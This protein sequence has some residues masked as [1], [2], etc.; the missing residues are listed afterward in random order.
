MTY[1]AGPVMSI[2]KFDTVEEAVARANN[3]IY[4]LGAGVCTR[5]IGKALKVAEQLQAREN[6][7]VFRLR[8]SQ[9]MCT[10]HFLHAMLRTCIDSR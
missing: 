1:G 3:S 8:M 10:P 2:L 7:V 6:L 9:C 4:G 5:D